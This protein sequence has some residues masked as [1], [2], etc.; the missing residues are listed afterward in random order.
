M[1]RGAE[2]YLLVCGSCEENAESRNRNLW[3]ILPSI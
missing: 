2:G 1:Y 3:K